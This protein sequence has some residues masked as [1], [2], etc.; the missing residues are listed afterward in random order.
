MPPALRESAGAQARRAIADEL[1][2]IR[3]GLERRSPELEVDLIPIF[4]RL[5][6][7]ASL[8]RTFYER[9]LTGSGLTHTEFQVLGILR[10]AGPR[11][12]TQLARSVGQTTAGMTKTLDRLE[13]SGLVDRRSH[14]SDRRRVEVALTRTGARRADGLQ[15]AEL[16]LQQEMLADLAPARRKDL[17]QNLDRIIESLVDGSQR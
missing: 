5:G 14:P 13:R 9:L 8:Y 11:S 7:V 1:E 12:P 6:A 4:G 17:V 2:E 15:R 10:G 3:A 16:E